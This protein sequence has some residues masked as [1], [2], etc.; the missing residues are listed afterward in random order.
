MAQPVNAFATND[1]VGIREDLSDIIYNVDPIETPFVSG[2]AKVKASQTLHEWQTERL[3]DATDDNAHPEGDDT[4]PSAITPTVR[5]SNR[6]QILKKSF[7]ISG[8]LE[9]TDRAGREAEAAHQKVKK[10]KEIRRDLEKIVTANRARVTGNDVLA[11]RMAGLGAWLAT[12]TAAGQ[13][14]ADPTGDGSNARTDGTQRAFT[15]TL[16]K[17]V[18]QDCWNNGG[19]PDTIMVG[20]FNKQQFSSFTGGATKFDKTEDKKLTAAIDVYVSDFGELSVVP[21]RFQ[22]ARDVFVMQ[23]DMWA[24]ANLRSLF[25]EPLA[26]TGDSNKWH[27]V[28]ECTLV[29]RNER[30]SGAVFDVT[31]A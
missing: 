14:G 26:K 20:S 19:D 24:V 16:L 30:A 28:M 13:G 7:V 29:S 25:T 9:A 10:A 17:D 1:A 5:L 15:E 11:P 31:T 4:A 27:M 8:T 6:T 3:D 18:L 2:I 22:R 21:N 12:N 23:M